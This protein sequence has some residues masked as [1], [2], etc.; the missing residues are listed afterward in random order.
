MHGFAQPMFSTGAT[1]LAT[2]R[3]KLPLDPLGFQA[4]GTGANVLRVVFEA[5]SGPTRNIRNLP[6]LIAAC[7]MANAKGATGWGS[8]GANRRSKT[9][10]LGSG[11]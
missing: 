11:R 6:E 2:I 5:R 10:P 3:D 8:V 4:L 1:V 7:E 9:S